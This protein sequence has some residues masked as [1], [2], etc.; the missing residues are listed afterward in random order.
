MAATHGSARI[1]MTDGILVTWERGIVTRSSAATSSRRSRPTR[2]MD[3][4]S[5]RDGFLS[6]PRALIGSTVPVGGPSFCVESKED[7][8][9]GELEMPSPG[10]TRPLSRPPRPQPQ[11]QLPASRC[12]LPPQLLRCR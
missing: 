3:V 11:V 1:T 7:V 4:E 12:P 8:E 9:G 6:G 2:I 5:F 10:S